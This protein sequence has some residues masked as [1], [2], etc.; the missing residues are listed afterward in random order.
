MVPD[1]SDS[2]TSGRVLRG[3]PRKGIGKSADGVYLKC[4]VLFFKLA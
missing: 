2:E 1:Q 3:K 4:D